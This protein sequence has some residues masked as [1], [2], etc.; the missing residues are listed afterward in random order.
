MLLAQSGFLQL[1]GGGDLI[2]YTVDLPDDINIIELDID[3]NFV[4]LN[5]TM[6][7]LE[8]NAINITD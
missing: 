1:A 7:I 6:D 8:L 2:L 5:T 4:K 3:N